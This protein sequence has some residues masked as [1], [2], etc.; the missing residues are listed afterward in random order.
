MIWYTRVGRSYML[1]WRGGVNIHNNYDNN[2]NSNK[3]SSVGSIII[4]LY[5]CVL[6]V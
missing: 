1:D 3:K 5:T 4:L 6:S 2:N